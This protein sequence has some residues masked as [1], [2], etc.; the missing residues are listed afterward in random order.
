[1]PACPR[2][3]RLLALPLI[4]TLAATGVLV[5]GTT[6]A[7]EADLS[8]RER[9]ILRAVKVARNQIGDPYRYGSAGPNSFDCSGL[10]SFAYGRAGLYLPRSS[11]AQYRYVRHIKKRN[12]RRGDLVF[13][14]SGGSVYHVG[15]YLRKKNGR[16]RILHAPSTGRT[17]NR[18]PIWTRSWYAGTLRPRR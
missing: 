12:I 17:V 14:H 15:I 11:D 13:F 4:V 6:T 9:K 1:M 5:G 7:A 10:T 8:A 2:W 18:D 3:R 16:H